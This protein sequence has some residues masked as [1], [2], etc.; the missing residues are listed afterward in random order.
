MAAL[1]PLFPHVSPFRLVVK[2]RTPISPK[3]GFVWEIIRDDIERRVGRSSVSYSSMAE[4][5]EHGAIEITRRRQP[6]Q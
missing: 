3:G 2:A 4:A 1:A 5:Y 6:A